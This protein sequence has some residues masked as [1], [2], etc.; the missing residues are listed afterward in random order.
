LEGHKID[1]EPRLEQV[2]SQLLQAIES[3]EREAP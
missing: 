3:F 1:D 2:R